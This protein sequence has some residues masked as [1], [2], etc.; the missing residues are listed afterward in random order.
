MPAG[1][2]WPSEWQGSKYGGYYIVVGYRVNALIEPVFKVDVCDPD[3]DADADRLK[4]MHFGLNLNFERKARLQV[5]YRESKV[6]GRFDDSAF[7]A[8]ASARF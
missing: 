3:K 2:A 1:G 6:A 8:Q 4:D 7:L 5:F